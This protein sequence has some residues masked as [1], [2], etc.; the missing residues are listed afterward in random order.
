V[1]CFI[2]HE[3]AHPFSDRG[4]QIGERRGEPVHAIRP[5]ELGPASQK[6]RVGTSIGGVRNLALPDQAS[7]PPVP[8]VQ[9][10]PPWRLPGFIK[11]STKRSRSLSQTRA[12]AAQ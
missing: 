3:V 10:K 5:S 1:R 7:G 6:T 8:E 9:L 2:M 12:S 11:L 4:M